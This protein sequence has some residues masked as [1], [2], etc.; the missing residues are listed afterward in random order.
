MS[1]AITKDEASV[2]ADEETSTGVKLCTDD[3]N[4]DDDDDAV[5]KLQKYNFC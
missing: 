3:A 1:F 4:D 5:R 2:N